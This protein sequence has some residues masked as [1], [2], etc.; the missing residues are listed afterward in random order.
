MKNILKTKKIII[1]LIIIAIILVGLGGYGI[2]HTLTNQNRNENKSQNNEFLVLFESNGGTFIDSQTISLNGKVEKPEDPVKIGFIFEGWEVDGITYDFNTK[3]TKDIVLTAVWKDDGITPKVMITFNTSEGSK[4]D[5]IEITKNTILNPPLN[6]TRSGYVFKGWFLNNKLFDFSLP[7]FEDITLE[8]QWE[9]NSTTNNSNNKNNTTNNNS[10]NGTNNQNPSNN[11]PTTDNSD[12]NANRFTVTFFDSGVLSIQIVDKGKT[13]TKPANP[14]SKNSS[15]PV[16]LHWM[17]SD[18]GKE[19]NFSTPITSNKTLGAVWGSQQP[20][21]PQQPTEKTFTATFNANGATSIGA[22]SLS[23]KTTGNSCT[24]TAPSISLTIINFDTGSPN[25]LSYSTNQ[26]GAFGYI[27]GWST[28][29][30]ETV[31]EFNPNNPN[32]GSLRISPS[33]SIELTGNKTYYAI[34]RKT[35]IAKWH[36]V[37]SPITNHCYAWNAATSC[38]RNVPSGTSFWDAEKEI[39]LNSTGP[40]NVVSMSG[41]RNFYRTRP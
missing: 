17:D 2:Y 36:F 41:H 8:A 34:T 24:I 20:S 40:N 25:T 37:G 18:T 23:C 28:S 30:N 31:S 11:N 35:F 13:V 19:F 27:F 5:S 15:F 33:Q 26:N 39:W 12:N 7:I 32:E 1:P 3:I 14:Q 29:S 9:K 22:T 21:E 38:L 6:P 10:N 4:I 16:F